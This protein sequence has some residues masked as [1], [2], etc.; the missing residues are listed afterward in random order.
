MLRRVSLLLFAGCALA[1]AE[2]SRTEAVVYGT[3]DRAPLDPAV[4]PEIAQTL[5]A[6]VPAD[7]LSIE[8]D[9]VTLAATTLAERLGGPLCDGERFATELSLSDC[10]AVLVAPD[11]VLTAAHCVPNDAACEALRVV[12]GYRR[13][14]GTLTPV[15]PDQVFQCVAREAE[16]LALDQVRLRLGRDTGRTPLPLGRARAGDAITIAGHPAGAPALVEELTVDRREGDGFVLYADV[17]DGSSG[18]PVIRDGTL[19]GILA[20]GETDY[21]WTGDCFASR[22]LSDGEGEGAWAS[23]VTHNGGCQAAGTP[24]PITLPLALLLLAMRAAPRQSRRRGASAGCA[25]RRD[26]REPRRQ[27]SERCRA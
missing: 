12:F 22:R 25:R 18:S 19:V 11:A 16:R 2:G 6:L 26:R 3:D 8:G 21:E 14:A 13:D 7:R 10:S 24:P 15:D 1:P 20:A 5:A 17:E 4:Y 9:R 27:S 23:D